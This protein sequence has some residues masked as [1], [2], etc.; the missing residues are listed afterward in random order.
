MHTICIEGVNYSS[1]STTSYLRY[2]ARGYNFLSCSTQLNIKYTMLINVNHGILT[3][4]SM[5]KATSERLKSRK[6][7]FLNILDFY[8]HKKVFFTL[9]PALLRKNSINQDEN[10]TN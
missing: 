5:I 10:P 8:L 7:F 1:D 4:I 2:L 9:G 6:V 3:F